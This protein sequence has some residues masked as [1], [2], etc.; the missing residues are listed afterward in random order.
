MSRFTQSISK[1][2]GEVL[3]EVSIEGLMEPKLQQTLKDVKAELLK[4]GGRHG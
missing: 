2:I 4:Y 1:S 3:G